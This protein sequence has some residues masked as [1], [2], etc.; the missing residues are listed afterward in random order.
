MYTIVARQHVH[1]VM[2]KAHT[3]RTRNNKRDKESQSKKS[4]LLL[5]VFACLWSKR[6]VVEMYTLTNMSLWIIWGK[7]RERV[8][9]SSNYYGSPLLL[10]L[11]A[12]NKACTYHMIII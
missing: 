10:S 3:L 6:E 12:E 1:V 11:C 5:K 7:E 9:D 4:S 2:L 8:R